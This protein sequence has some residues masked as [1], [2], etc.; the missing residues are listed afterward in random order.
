MVNLK[1]GKVEIELKGSSKYAVD[2]VRAPLFDFP[3]SQ[4]GN[5]PSQNNVSF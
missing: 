2:L 1:N 3:F 4:I 5:A